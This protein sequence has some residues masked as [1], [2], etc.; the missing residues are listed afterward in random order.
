MVVGFNDSGSFGETYFTTGGL[1]EAGLARSTDT[2]QMFTDLGFLNPG[3]VFTDVLFGDPVVACTDA[4]TFYYSSLS[5][6]GPFG[7][8][9]L[10]GISASI[11]INLTCRFSVKCSSCLHENF[12][13]PPPRRAS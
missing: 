7:A 10:S 1:S 5:P 3:P 4:D 8:G 12:L 6:T 9:R 11:L 2:G 13:P